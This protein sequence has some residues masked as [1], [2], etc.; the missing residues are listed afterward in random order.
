MDLFTYL[1]AK[2]DHNT[3]VKK[4]LFSYL[5]GK[6]QSGT[7]QDYSGTSLSIN[8]TKKGKMKLLLSGNT[9]QDGTPTPDAPQTIHN[10]NGDNSVNVYGKN[11]TDGSTYLGGFINSQGVAASSGIS[12]FT[13]N[14]G[15]VEFTT[16]ANNRGIYSDYIQIEPSTS[17]VVSY[18]KTNTSSTYHNRF[19]WYDKDKTFISRQEQGTY[20]T[21]PANAKYVRLFL[22][23]ETA[24][25]T[26]I[27]NIMFNNGTTASP[28]TPY[29]S[30][31]YPVNLGSIELNKISTYKD[32]FIINSGK[33]LCSNVT[34]V[35]NTTIKF[36]L[37][38]PTSKN[39]TLQAVI[40][41]ATSS[42]SIY[43]FIDGNN[44]GVIG[45]ITGS[46]NANATGSI[47]LTDEKY[48]AIQNSSDFYFHLYKSG[49]HFDTPTNVMLNEGS[50]ALP[51]E[52]YGSGEWYLK[53]E[54]GK[55]V[56]DGSENWQLYNAS[57]T[58]ARRFGILVTEM[59]MIGNGKSNYFIVEANNGS[60]KTQNV[61]FLQITSS[62]K[63]IGIADDLYTWADVAALKT[64]LSSHNTILDYVQ[65]TPTYTKITDT[66]L[67]NQLE[68]VYRANSY[69]DQT[70]ISQTNNDLPFNLDVEVKV[71]A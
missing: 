51:Y 5:L 2:N 28:Y 31:T 25:T 67:I 9:S 58:I 6:G 33:N 37:D 41:E 65:A 50:T 38:K 66:N 36:E 71:S 10:V 44:E 23:L 63:Y 35:S 69:K 14:N 22:E 12:S 54:I 40:N 16:S 18:E 29:T 60:N 49:A 52:P 64:W 62:F 20:L 4:D 26:T 57:S 48:E 59:N 45:N 39:L 19:C 11:L 3:S 43:L 70:N 68:E 46:A 34:K 55:V 53:K 30:A 1:M 24:G 32:G 42:N 13:N 8:N 56:L 17:Y 21:S 27:S 61:L 47:T 7:Y 15:V